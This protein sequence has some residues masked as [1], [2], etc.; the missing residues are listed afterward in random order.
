MVETCL[1]CE[2][3]INLC[4]IAGKPVFHPN[5]GAG[6]IGIFNLGFRQSGLVMDAPIHRTQA[7]IDSAVFNEIKQLA[8]DHRLILRRHGGIWLVPA[9][10]DT[11]ALELLALNIE[12]F[13]GVLAA[14]SA[15][16]DGRHLQ[17]FAAKRSHPP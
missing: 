6:V 2:S 1:A 11:E 12:I 9:A 3:R 13:F 7:F 10:E 8:D 15:H 14:L 4:R 5:A 17:L 16:G